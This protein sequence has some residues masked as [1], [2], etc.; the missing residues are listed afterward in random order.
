MLTSDNEEK[1]KGS[2]MVARAGDTR[3]YLHW[4][5]LAWL[6]AIP[7]VLA[8]RQSVVLYFV[9]ALPPLILIHEL[10][11]LT[12]LKFLGYRVCSLFLGAFGG[13]VASEPPA[14]LRHGLLIYSAG[15]GAQLLVLIGT[16]L[17]T[18]ALGFPTSLF[19][20][21]TFYVLT[22]GNLMVIVT[23]LIPRTVNGMPSD[24]LVLWRL[25]RFALGKEAP[26]GS[27][28]QGHAELV[29]MDAM[30][31]AGFTCGL[32]ILNDATTPMEFVVAVLAKYLQ[33]PREE[34]TA[35]MLQVHREGG[36]LIPTATMALA[37]QIA[38]GITADARAAGHVL[39]CKAVQ[40]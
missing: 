1:V 2:V 32:Q 35:S 40:R 6:L 26:H 20:L 28:L 31:P 15:V 16:M 37:I 34:A 27:L 10:G 8:I 21:F 11:H 7:L 17:A 5:L 33:M 14:T 39:A 30:V 4:S 24:G 22:L 38:A 25:T 3:V 23:S 12:A 36:V 9:L 29:R 19:W 13:H 18:L